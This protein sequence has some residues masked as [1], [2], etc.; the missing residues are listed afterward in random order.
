MVKAFAW[1]ENIRSGK[2]RGMRLWSKF[3]CKAFRIE[4]DSELGG[5]L[6]LDGPVVVRAIMSG[7]SSTIKAA[8]V[9][10]QEL[11]AQVEVRDCCIA[12]K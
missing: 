6:T 8:I 11:A 1:L 9:R 7:Q 5:W 2:E 3:V 10:A 4:R 12:F